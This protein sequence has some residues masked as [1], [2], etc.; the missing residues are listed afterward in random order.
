MRARGPFVPLRQS[1]PA[2]PIV[3]ITS[4]DWGQFRQY[5]QSLRVFVFNVWS[6]DAVPTTA[7]IVCGPSVVPDGYFNFDDYF[8]T[9]TVDVIFSSRARIEA[10]IT[11]YST[12]QT[13]QTYFE[14]SLPSRTSQVAADVTLLAKTAGEIRCNATLTSSAGTSPPGSAT[15]TVIGDDV[16]F[17][18]PPARR[19]SKQD[20]DV[21]LKNALDPDFVWK[22]GNC[23][24]KFKIAA[25]EFAQDLGL[26]TGPT[27]LF[28][29]AGHASCSSEGQQE[30]TY[31]G[32][33]FEVRKG[34]RTRVEWI[35]EL[36]G[37]LDTV[38][39]DTTIHWALGAA[40]PPGTFPDQFYYG[41]MPMVTHL[42]GGR[43]EPASDGHPETW[44]LAD[45]AYLNSNDKC[46]AALETLNAYG[47]GIPRQ[48][49]AYRKRDFVY[50]NEQ[51]AGNLWYHDHTL[52]IT[53]LGPYTGLAG[54]YLIRTDG[55][56]PLP[57]HPYEVPI[58]IQ[59][60]DFYEDGRLRREPS[61]SP[62]FFGSVFLAN[63][64]A[65]ERS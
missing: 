9:A 37:P 58:A 27:P 36:C 22:S 34:L 11:A 19:P 62:E 42:H 6:G 46:R 43:T 8:S 31:P 35:N 47:E 64:K 7:N 14:D 45:E 18:L 40:S 65:S 10:H 51:E 39:V 41:P 23:G 38:P 63:G 49:P 17:V 33:T 28:G 54:F 29:Y 52:G 13:I 50:S 1:L 24:G 2:E 44:F 3:F 32:R 48:G 61:I 57:V 5:Q 55:F 59:D 56:L 4:T 53:R 30:P 60:K 26:G 16:P 15:A 25:R 20:L 21:Q 12:Q